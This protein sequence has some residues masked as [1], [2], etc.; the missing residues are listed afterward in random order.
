MARHV[1]ADPA[2]GQVQAVDFGKKESTFAYGANLEFGSMKQPLN[3]RF[4]AAYATNSDVPLDNVGCST[5]A[6]RSTVLTA[7]G[8]LVIRPLPLPLVRPY[9]VVGAGAKWY[10]FD[11]DRLDQAGV[12]GYLKDQTR[13]TG[14]LGAGVSLFPESMFHLDAEVSDYISQFDFT[15]GSNTMQ[16]DLFLKLLFAIGIGPH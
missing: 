2:L 11:E 5:C 4:D 1:R 3:V 14:Q 12:G 10:N 16:H 13:L 8:A 9:A 15:N 6:L 7:T